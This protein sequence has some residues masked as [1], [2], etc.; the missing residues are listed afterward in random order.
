[1]RR[2]QINLIHLTAF[3][4]YF[5]IEKFIIPWPIWA[6]SD[7]LL[8]ERLPTLIEAYEDNAIKIMLYHKLGEIPEPQLTHRFC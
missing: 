1:M 6:K 5:C 2:T 7:R 4:E 8:A 3:V